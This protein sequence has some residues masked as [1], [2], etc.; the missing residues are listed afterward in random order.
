M[1]YLSSL[2]TD[3]GS[4]RVATEVELGQSPLDPRGLRKLPCNNT[5][6][7]GLSV[8]GELGGKLGHDKKMKR[9][10]KRQFITVETWDVTYKTL[11]KS[12]D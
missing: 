5:A 2:Y 11:H 7:V 10:V 1:A 9:H 4:F 8:F 12:M 6:A 3:D